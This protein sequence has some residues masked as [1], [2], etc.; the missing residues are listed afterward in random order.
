MGHEPRKTADVVIAE[1]L[2]KVSPFSFDESV[3][4]YA[5]LGEVAAGLGE[6]QRQALEKADQAQ[7]MPLMIKLA[8]PILKK[9]FAMALHVD[10]TFVGENVDMVAQA[11]LI[12]AIAEVNDIPLFI[13]QL[14]RVA[15]LLGSKSA[16]A[17]GSRAASA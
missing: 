1:R 10:E 17:G 13:S 12:Q 14:R 2:Y 4:I 16:S 7:M 15:S 5:M 6:T 11:S 8:A 9:V 3:E